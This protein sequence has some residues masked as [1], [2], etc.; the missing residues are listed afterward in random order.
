MKKYIKNVFVLGSLALILV[1]VVL[2]V[3]SGGSSNSP[4]GTMKKFEKAINDG[5]YKKAVSCLSEEFM[6][7]GMSDSEE[8]ERGAEQ[9]EMKFIVASV[10]T[11]SSE[12]A[13]VCTMMTLTD[14]ETGEREMAQSEFGMVKESGKWRIADIY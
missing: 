5:N 6:T 11:L 13:T 9:Y 1:C 7:Y 12:E 8:F 4:E 14:K 2:A 3:V 10:E